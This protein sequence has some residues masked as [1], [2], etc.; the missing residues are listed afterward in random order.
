MKIMFNAGHGISTAGKRTPDGAIR[1][2]TLNDKVVDHLMK[3]AVQYENVVVNRADDPTGSRDVPL[4][5]RVNKAHAWGAAVYVSIHHNAAGSGWNTARGTEV[6]SY[7]AKS[8][9]ATALAKLVQAEIVHQMGT[10]DRGVKHENFYELRAT[11]IPAI[12]VECEFYTNKDAV[13]LMKTAT[14]GEKMAGA[15]MHGIA[16]HYGL[17]KKAGTAAKPPAT[18]PPVTKPPATKPP[19]TSTSK[20][21]IHRVIVDGKQVGAYQNNGSVGNAV[22]KALAANPKKITIEIV[23]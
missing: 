5:E 7:S 18:K 6:F 3:L 12:L 14:Y 22:E 8:T 23:D 20:D 16:R 15:I 21:R 1:E 4:A 13:A 11:K 9:A 2:W 10:K 19:T 17:K